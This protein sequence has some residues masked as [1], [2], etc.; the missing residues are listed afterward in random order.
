MG[1]VE[2]LWDWCVLLLAWSWGS[3]LQSWVPVCSQSHQH[4]ASAGSSF[5]PGVLV[6]SGLCYHQ[7]PLSQPV[8]EPLCFRE[9]FK[10]DVNLVL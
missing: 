7:L 10:L 3:Q 8:L 4:P 1:S 5:A 6:S 2:L 9:Q